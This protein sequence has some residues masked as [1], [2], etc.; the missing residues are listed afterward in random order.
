MKILYA[1]VVAI[2][3]NACS[4]IGPSQTLP[5]NKYFSINLE[6]IPQEQNYKKEKTIIVALPKGLDYSSAIFYKKD[7]MVNAYAYH[8][9]KQ[10]PALMI[11]DFLE[12]HLQD[13]NAFKAVLNQDSL[14][15]ADYVL[16]SK[17][18]VLEQEFSDEMHSK[19]K[20]GISLNW[21]HINTKKL[22][23]S[24]YFYY[25]KKLTDNAP[26]VLIQNYNELFML[27]A[28]DFRLWISQNLE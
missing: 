21:V 10:N 25:E 23:A 5:A 15:S 4:L 8:F 16:E 6:K 7:H 22:L 3:F 1:I 19:I 13:L 2:F 28:K 12:F 27:F 24:K 11:K 14:A 26:E 9:W 17:V 18:D 20:F